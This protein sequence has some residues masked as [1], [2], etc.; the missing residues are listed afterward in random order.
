MHD[1]RI[2]HYTNS[3]YDLSDMRNTKQKGSLRMVIFPSKDSEYRYTAACI[4][5][6]IVR[7]G[8]DAFELLQELQ[9]AS[10]HYLQNVI[11]HYLSDDLL[12]QTLPKKYLDAYKRAERAKQKLQPGAIKSPIP[13]SELLPWEK[14]IATAYETGSRE[15]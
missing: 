12:N 6:A 1:D 2:A 11:E 4:E 15:L 8:D 5:L 13:I 3:C 9:S 14:S 7:E 10:R